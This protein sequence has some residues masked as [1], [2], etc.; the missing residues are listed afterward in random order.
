MT[1]TMMYNEFLN[2][3]GC[4]NNEHN[5]KL[6]ERLEAMYNNTD[7]TKEEI[8]EFGKKLADNSLTEEE[9]RHNMLIDEKI[10]MLNKELEW[11]KGEVERLQ[12][13][14]MMGD[15]EERWIDYWK[16]E[17]RRKQNE[18]KELR[19]KIRL[20]EETKAA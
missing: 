12:I 18:I 6:F 16:C 15:D 10:E 7:M 5:F 13:Y 20:L 19:S 14:L 1:K 11:A 2:G 9:I 4:K 3:T 17:K 8:Y